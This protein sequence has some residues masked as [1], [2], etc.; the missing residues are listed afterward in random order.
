MNVDHVDLGYIA[1]NTAISFAT[2]VVV[3]VVIS[4]DVVVVVI[5]GDQPLQTICVVANHSFI[6]VERRQLTIAV[7]GVRVVVKQEPYLRRRKTKAHVIL[8]FRK[9]T[10]CHNAKW[11][12]FVK[13]MR[14]SMT[15]IVE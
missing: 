10:C 13:K 11:F 14:K 6:N 8:I 7:V 9:H 2:V 3:V 4:T 12:T 15:V 1:T 5:V